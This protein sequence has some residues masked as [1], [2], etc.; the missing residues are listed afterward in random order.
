MAQDQ[1]RRLFAEGKTGRSVQWATATAGVF[2]RV[3]PKSEAE[4][5]QSTL[6]SHSLAPTAR[7]KN[8]AHQPLPRTGWALE[9]EKRTAIH[10]EC[11]CYSMTSSA[12]E[13]IDGGTVRPRASAV[14]RLTTSSNVVGCWTGRSAGFSPLRIRP[15]YTPACRY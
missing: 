10:A 1:E 6:S 3:K 4:S 13:R 5:R 8:T 11:G 12:R 15:M 2:G 14:L 9:A 7:V